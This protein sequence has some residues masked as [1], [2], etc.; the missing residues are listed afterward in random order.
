MSG[1]QKK[2]KNR[3]RTEQPPPTA[4]V[5]PVDFAP[6]LKPHRG[7]FAGLFIVF[8]GWVVFL[9]VLYVKTV[10]RDTGVPPVLTAPNEDR[11]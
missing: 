5:R 3:P 1:G 11:R 10:H 6:P 2:K 7:L 8:V 4:S 9:I